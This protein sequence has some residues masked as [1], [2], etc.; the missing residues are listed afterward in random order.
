MVENNKENRDALVK[1]VVETWDMGD[2]VGFAM[3][4]LAEH[5]AASTDL[6]NEDWSATMDE[7]KGE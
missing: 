7:A 4:Y 3:H 6:F 2:L 5:Y 1:E